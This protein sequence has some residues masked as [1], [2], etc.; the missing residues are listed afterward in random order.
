ML[1]FRTLHI[2]GKT[3]NLFL[4]EAPWNICYTPKMI[5]PLTGHE[6]KGVW[7]LE[8][9]RCFISKCFNLYKEY[10]EEYNELIVKYDISNKV[11]EY[12]CSIK[13][14]YDSRLITRFAKDCNRELS[15]IKI[16]DYI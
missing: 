1:T 6:A 15:P 7:P 10:I 13:N 16:E 14:E 5:D 4:F 12:I 9:Q 2:F 8:Y 11:N 3:K